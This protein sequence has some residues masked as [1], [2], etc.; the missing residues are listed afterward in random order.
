MIGISI[1]LFLVLYFIFY[2]NGK[3]MQEV[4]SDVELIKEYT[5]VEDIG[6]D[7]IEYKLLDLIH[8]GSKGTYKIGTRYFVVLSTGS[9]SMGGIVYTQEA[10][11]DGGTT[12]Y[13]SLSEIGEDTSLGVRYKV[14]EF[15][16][17]VKVEARYNE[18]PSSLSGILDGIIYDSGSSGEKVFFNPNS[19][20]E[21]KI[22]TEYTTGIYS[23]SI[24]ENEI[25]SIEELD[26]IHVKDCVITEHILDDVYKIQFTGGHILEVRLDT[27]NL[28]VGSHI[29]ILLSGMNNFYGEVI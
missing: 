20:I 13:Y 22:E 10:N 26:K 24:L 7:E 12:V 6:N 23:L 15:S 27:L 14:L 4:K 18:I 25:K 2:I 28:N 29:Q 16:G 9:E 19:G 5:Q 8:S 3:K 11:A 17:P 1:A 21:R